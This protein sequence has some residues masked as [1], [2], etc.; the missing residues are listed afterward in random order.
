M[1]SAPTEARYT[2]TVKWF[3]PAKYYGFIAVRS[4]I[5]NLNRPDLF[6][7]AN[8]VRGGRPISEGQTV[9][10]LVET[11]RNGRLCA[12]DVRVE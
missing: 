7:H 8:A 1:S 6:V 9:S 2:G 11:D 3:D 5:P 12:A 4:T 10:F